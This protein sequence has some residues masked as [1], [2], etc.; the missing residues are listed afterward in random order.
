MFLLLLSVIF[1]LT[2]TPNS[3]SATSRKIS[4]DHHLLHVRSIVGLNLSLISEPKKIENSPTHYHSQKFSTVPMLLG[5]KFL[6]A[7]L[8]LRFLMSALNPVPIPIFNPLYY[9]HI[10]YGIACQQ[11][12]NRYSLSSF[13]HSRRLPVTKEFNNAR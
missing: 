1:I 8:I 6:F 7:I 12:N 2:M 5:V 13:L 3:Y 10:I 9:K 11:Q 4:V